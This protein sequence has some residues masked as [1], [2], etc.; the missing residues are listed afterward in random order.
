MTGRR[1]VVSLAVAATALCALAAFVELAQADVAPPPS[2]RS[3]PVNLV[4]RRDRSATHSK[5]QIPRK[6]LAAAPQGEGAAEGAA[7]AFPLQSVVAGMA[8]SLAIVS[9]VV[10]I[11]RMGRRSTMAAATAVSLVA[12]VVGLWA[13]SAAVADLA[14]PG[15]RPAGQKIVIE[16]TD[17]GDAVVLTLG[18]DV[19]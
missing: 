1:A 18:R 13:A 5:I 16:V 3:E 12:G 17:R 15:R 6:F 11:R 14:V 2:K 19:R 4:V 7:A 10:V 8:L 9:G